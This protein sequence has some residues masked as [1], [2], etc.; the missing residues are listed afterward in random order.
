MSRTI[1]KRQYEKIKEDS[2][3]DYCNSSSSRQAFTTASSPIISPECSKQNYDSYELVTSKLSPFFPG[4]ENS[5]IV[6][7]CL[8]SKGVLYES[9]Q[10]QVGYVHFQKN[11]HVDFTLFLTAQTALASIGINIDSD[12]KLIVHLETNEISNLS[13]GKQ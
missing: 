12:D 9:S 11:K 10:I 13:E 6:R 8:Q 4:K 5:K 7:N 3:R 2:R 1:I